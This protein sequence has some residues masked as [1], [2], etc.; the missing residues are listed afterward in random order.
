MSLCR[1]KKRSYWRESATK[2][3]YFILTPNGG[4]LRNTRGSLSCRE[5]KKARRQDY[6]KDLT[7]G[8]RIVGVGNFSCGGGGGTGGREVSQ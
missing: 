8:L 6:S 1:R 2:R 4:Y 5:R 3:S 7:G